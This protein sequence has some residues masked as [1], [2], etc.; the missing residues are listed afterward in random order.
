MSLEELFDLTGKVGL[1]TGGNSGLGFGFAT[2]MAKGGADVVIWGR[3]VD[4][5]EEAAARLRTH[6]V[7]VLAQAIDVTDER[8]VRD[9]MTRAVEAMGRV[10]CVVANAGISSRPPSFHEMPSEMYH[11]LLATSL[12]GAF[13]TLREGVAHMVRRAEA[14]DPGGS[15]IVC[16]SLTVVGGVAR[17]EHYAAAKGA[18]LAVTRSVAVEYGRYGIRANMVAPGFIETSLGAGRQTPEQLA[19]REEKIRTRS[20]IPRVGYPS[21]FEGVIVYLMSDAASYHTGDCIVID[22]GYSVSI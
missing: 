13:Y 22:G 10:D 11:E 15:L 9:G 19:L 2:G 18:M 14:G 20:P 4:K 12:H 16:G 1:V 5:N 17:I 6:G 7:R 8:Q 21:D 3:R